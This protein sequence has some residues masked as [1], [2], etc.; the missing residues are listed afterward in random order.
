MLILTPFKKFAYDFVK[1]LI[2]MVFGD[3]K[4]TFVMN[5]AK[6]EEEYGDNGNRIHEKRDVDN[7]YKVR[8]YLFGCS[9]FRT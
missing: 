5:S 9:Y 4:K 6:F 2:K 1:G 3:E 8:E 7:E